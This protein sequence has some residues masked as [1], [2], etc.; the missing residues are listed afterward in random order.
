M[1]NASSSGNRLEIENTRVFR[2]L[3][4]ETDQLQHLE[5]EGGSFTIFVPSNSAFEG[6]CQANEEL[7]LKIE[8][9]SVK[10][11][12]E[13]PFIL[14]S[15]MRRCAYLSFHHISPEISIFL[16]LSEELKILEQLI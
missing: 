15:R 7:C 2:E 3:M 4:L 9:V 14:F 5:K 10:F 12:I 8:Q 13:I 6:L 11:K 1:E 16:K